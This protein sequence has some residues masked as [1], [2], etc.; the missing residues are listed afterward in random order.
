MF[1]KFELPISI[2]FEVCRRSQ[3]KK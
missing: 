3:N 2:S 1:A